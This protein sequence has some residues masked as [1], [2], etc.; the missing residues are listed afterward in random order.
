[1]DIIEDVSQPK[2]L[3]CVSQI[4]LARL[5]KMLEMPRRDEICL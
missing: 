2:W 3:A 1:V 5:E 4:E